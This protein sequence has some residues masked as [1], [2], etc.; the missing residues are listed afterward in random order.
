MTQNSTA[1]SLTH[2]LRGGLLLITIGFGVTMVPKPV[3]AIVCCP[4]CNC[5][6]CKL[7]VSKGEEEGYCWEIE[8][9]EICVP[10][11]V[12][13]WQNPKRSCDRDRCCGDGCCRRCLKHNGAFV[14]HVKK[15][16]KRKYKCPK[17]EYEWNLAHNGRCCSGKCGDCCEGES[18]QNPQVEEKPRV[19]DDEDN[20]DVRTNYLIPVS[21]LRADRDNTSL[22]SN[23]RG[24]TSIKWGIPF[25]PVRR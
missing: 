5:S 10:R 18:C 7:N 2:R 22:Q 3:A 6:C 25:S 9:E 1:F 15:P 8:C 20:D 17:C 23:K 24:A 21:H 19:S 11:V 14:V 12:F 13:P 16:K 4:K